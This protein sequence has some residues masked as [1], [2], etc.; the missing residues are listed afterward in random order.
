MGS[1][2]QSLELLGPNLLF[3]IWFG[4][5][6]SA[7]ERGGQSFLGT[8][9]SQFSHALVNHGTHLR[10]ALLGNSAIVLT[11]YTALTQTETAIMSLGYVILWDHH[12]VHG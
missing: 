1:P 2:R 7:S 3:S 4:A 5:F 10:N 11:A 6:S 8:M 9:G 12:D